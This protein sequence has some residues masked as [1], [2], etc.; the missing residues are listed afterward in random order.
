MEE[1]KYE[2]SFSGRSG[3][4][5]EEYDQPAAVLFQLAGDRG[6][7]HSG[8]ALIQCNFPRR[9]GCIYHYYDLLVVKILF[10]MLIRGP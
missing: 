8:Y 3:K 2:G 5:A 9:A 6:V 4:Q 1:W 10:H 7:R